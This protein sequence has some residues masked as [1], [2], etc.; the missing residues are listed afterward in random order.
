MTG[1]GEIH[2]DMSHRSCDG[3]EIPDWN[4]APGIGRSISFRLDG[5]HLLDITQDNN[6]A[7]WY[8]DAGSRCGSLSSWVVS[9]AIVHR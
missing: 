4:Q 1:P 7:F 3:A 5:Y 8:V 6:L 9:V 2:W